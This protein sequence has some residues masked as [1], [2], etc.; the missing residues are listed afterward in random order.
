M[1][2]SVMIIWSAGESA[3]YCATAVPQA[4]VACPSA[5]LLSSAGESASYCATAVQRVN[6]AYPGAVILFVLF[7]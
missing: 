5:V 7:P 1:S 6:V 4:N 2:K 3:S